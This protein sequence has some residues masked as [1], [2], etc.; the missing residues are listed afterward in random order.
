MDVNSTILLCLYILPLILVVYILKLVR[1]S[2][3]PGRL[4]M[5][6]Q[7][8]HY[9][10]V[11]KESVVEFYKRSDM[12]QQFEE[13]G[14]IAAGFTPTKFRIVRD[15]S[16]FGLAV[17]LNVRYL[18]NMDHQ[19]PI[20]ALLLL[21]ILYI[22]LQ[23][24]ASFPIVYFLKVVKIRFERKKN[25]EIF[26]LQQL[27]SNE[28][29]D[30]NT[31]K[32]N[33]YHMFL[34]MRRFLNYIRPAID[35]FLEEYPLDPFNKGK[36]FSSFAKIVGTPEAESLAE[37]LYQVD[38]SSPEEVAEIL[39]KKYEELKKRRQENYRGTMRDRGL[40]AYVL[41]FSGIMMVIICGLFVYYLEYKDMMNATY[42][43]H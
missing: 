39:E 4:S 26:I 42:N 2:L 40:F 35:R 24:R 31:T 14:L 1:I 17:L 13:A 11:Q 23:L 29:A 18:M 19:Y 33:V 28:Y 10:D 12:L 22:V 25:A 9:F 36:A 5:W 32:Q 20:F 15:A 7:M 8:R 34:Y 41:T 6:T 43:M 3:D 37:I 30:M 16:I 27:I 38:Q 21:V